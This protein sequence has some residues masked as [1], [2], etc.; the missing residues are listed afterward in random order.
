MP[1]ACPSVG[2][3]VHVPFC[4]RI[5]PYCDFAVVAAPRLENETQR[6]YVDA[7]LRELEASAEAFDGRALATL[8][9][10]GGTPS[11]LLPGQLARVLDAVCA[12]FGAE[13]DSVEIT[14]EAN[15][16][17][18]ERA[19]LSG[20]REVGVNRL[21]LGV[22][23]FNAPVLQRLGRAHRAEES[24]LAIEAA[25]AAGFSNL[26]LDLIFGAPGG[27]AAQLE[28]DL[29]AVLAAA[30]EHVSAYQLT[31]EPQT[32]FELAAER[33]Q[34]TLP[35]A[36]EAA[37]LME[38]IRERLASGG[39]ERYEVSNYAQPGF[40]SRHNQRYWLREPVLGLGLGA[41]TSEP[42]RSG[43]PH[44]TRRANTRELPRYLEAVEQGR[45]AAASVEVLDPRTARGEAVFLAL[46]RAQ[47]LSARAFVRA[48]GEPP[49]HWFAA[50]IA[51]LA[52][53]GLLQEAP[54]GDLALTAR[55]FLL[56]DEVAAHFV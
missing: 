48:F 40:A 12:R 26:S 51:T 19:Q 14:L 15:P 38:R 56:A 27:S 23:S 28:R 9:L 22:Q 30:P 39:F 11:L 29:E 13:C 44:G 53:A 49:R 37:A 21:S 18:L 46:R 6:R 8:Y 34:F 5:C 55:G 7:L 1:Q 24:H 45:S 17:S 50:E 47:G 16:S 10:G 35:E 52:D 43:A 2:V 25:R 42:G 41:V 4:E 33:G 32:P 20:F 3:Y 36:D 54:G 31:V